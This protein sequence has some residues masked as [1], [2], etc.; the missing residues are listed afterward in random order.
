MQKVT[1]NAAIGN[2]V[3]AMLDIRVGFGQKWLSPLV[4]VSGCA[5]YTESEL[6]DRDLCGLKVTWERSSHFWSKPT[7][8][9]SCF[10]SFV[11]PPVSLTSF[12]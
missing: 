2:K 12:H 6:Y 11:L 5:A 1:V 8:A 10:F 9:F 7:L 3:E 4:G